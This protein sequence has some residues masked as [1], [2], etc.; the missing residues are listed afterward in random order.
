MPMMPKGRYR[1]MTDY[2][3]RVGTLG[4]QMM[5]RTCTVQVNLDFDRGG[6][7]Q[8]LRV[9]LAL[10]PVANALS[11]IAFLDGKARTAGKKKLARAYLAEPFATPA[12]ACCLCLQDGM[13]L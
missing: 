11:P 3:G 5:Y 9:A 4:T 8:K 10:Q 6:H 1:L 12:P 7:G 13:G 2:M